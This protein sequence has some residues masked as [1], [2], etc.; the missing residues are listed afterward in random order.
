MP[1]IERTVAKDKPGRRGKDTEEMRCGCG[2]R[3]FRVLVEPIRRKEKTRKSPDLRVGVECPLCGAE[4]R[5]MRG[6]PN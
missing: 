5:I 2:N 6:A 1:K 4:A 3:L